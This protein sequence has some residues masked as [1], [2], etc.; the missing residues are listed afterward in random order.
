M[1]EVSNI[2]H[3]TIDLPSTDAATALSG[4]GNTYLKKFESQNA[5]TKKFQMVYFQKK[6]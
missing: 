3:F 5:L 2:G 1:K 4:Q 6:T